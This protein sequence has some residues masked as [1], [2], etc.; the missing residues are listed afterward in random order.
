M[1]LRSRLER[2]EATIDA[3]P[4]GRL[5]VIATAEARDGEAPG[6]IELDG[7]GYCFP[8]RWERPCWYL[9][10]PA[11]LGDDPDPIAALTEEQ[12]AFL[13]PTDRVVLACE[14][15]LPGGGGLWSCEIN[16]RATPL[17]EVLAGRDDWWRFPH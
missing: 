9:R 5:V 6:T 16:D 14:F 4:S 17:A 10:V 13:E 7:R 2:L 3:R 15:V 12:R 8:G 11:E 1:S